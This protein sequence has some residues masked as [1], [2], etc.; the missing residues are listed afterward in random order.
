MNS[1]AMRRVRRVKRFAWLG[2]IQIVCGESVTACPQAASLRCK[3]R[4]LDALPAA[5]S[6]PLV[7][8]LPCLVSLQAFMLRQQDPSNPASTTNGAISQIISVSPATPCYASL[9]GK[10][11]IVFDGYGGVSTEN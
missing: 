10:R 7:Q 9:K 1:K 11:K 5:L 8:G 4:L 2:V 6:L 3:R